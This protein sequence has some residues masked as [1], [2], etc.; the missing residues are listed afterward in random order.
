MKRVAKYLSGPIF[1]AVFALLP[2][3]EALGGGWSRLESP[4]TAALYRITFTGPSTGTAVGQRGLILRTRDGGI[5]WS[6]QTIGGLDFLS[7]VHFI[8]DSLG[9]VVG[10]GGAIFRTSDGGTTW[11]SQRTGPHPHLR[12]VFLNDPLRGTAVGDS[13][14]IL[15]TTD[16]G[17]TWLNQASPTSA[18]LTSVTF[19]GDSTGI[20]VGEDVILKTTDAGG[21]WRYVT[22]FGNL[23]DVSFADSLNGLSVG[24]FYGNGIIIKTTDGGETWHP[25]STLTL[26]TIWQGVSFPSPNYAVAVGNGPTIAHSTDGGHTWFYALLPST[27]SLLLS[28]SFVDSVTGFAAGTMGDLL[29]TTDGG[30]PILLLAPGN[31]SFSDPKSVTLTWHPSILR[32][33]RLQVSTVQDFSRNIVLDNS[34]LMDTVKVL[35]NLA[36]NTTYYWRVKGSSPL[37]ESPWSS[38][39]S[40]TTFDYPPVTVRELQEIS[41]DSL[42]AADSLQESDPRRWTL[43]ASAFLRD[44]VTFLGICVVP[45]GVII[46]DQSSNA[47]VVSDTTTNEVPWHG[48]LVQAG[49]GMPLGEFF[50]IEQGDLIKCTGVVH[51]DPEGSM[52]SN[53]LFELSNVRRIVRRKIPTT[54]INSVGNF[55]TGIYPQGQVRYSTGEQYEGMLVEFRNLT[56]VSYK[57]SLAGTFNVADG[58]GALISTTDASS[59]FTF[60]GHRDPFSTYSLPPRG[61]HIRLLRGLLMTDGMSDQ[62]RGYT[63]APILPGDLVIGFRG[64]TLAGILFNDINKN[65]IQDAGEPGFPGLRVDLTGKGQATILTDS[66]GKYH[67]SDLDPGTYTVH[68]RLPEGWQPVPPGADSLVVSLGLDDSV[69]GKN[70]PNY[71]RGNTISGRVVFDRRESG[72][73]HPEDQPIPDCRITVRGPTIDS[74]LTG[75]GGEYSFIRL[76]PGA[77]T[78]SAEARTGWQQSYPSA[79]YSLTLTGFGQEYPNTNF[80]FHRAQPRIRIPVTVSDLKIHVHKDVWWGVRP[81]ASYGLWGIDP[82][83]TIIDSIEGEFE[84]PPRSFAVIYGFFDTRLEDPRRLKGLF[85]EG[86]WTDIR[87]FISTAQRD[88]HYISFLPAYISGGGYPM[89]LRWSK[90][91]IRSS[92]NGPVTITDQASQTLDMK[93]VDSLLVTDNRI[94]SVLIT[95]QGPNLPAALTKQW[96]LVSVPP[97]YGST[98][99]RALFPSTVSPAF[100]WRPDS[101]YATDAEL[102]P[103]RGYW[104]NCSLAADT[105]LLLNSSPGAVDTIIVRKGWNIIGSAD[106]SV[107]PGTIESVPP[108]I[109]DGGILEYMGRYSLADTLEPF[110]GYWVKT[111]SDGKLILNPDHPFMKTA[112]DHLAEAREVLS[113][114]GKLTFRDAAGAE[115]EL[116]FS[117]GARI[118]GIDVRYFDLPPSPPAGI[119]D[120]RFA[121]GHMVETVEAGSRRSCAITVSSESYPLKIVWERQTDT[122]SASLT[123]GEKQFVMNS[124][125]QLTLMKPPGTIVLTLIGMIPLPEKFALMQNY[126]NPFNPLTAI[127]F[128][129]PEDCRVKLTLYDILGRQV[130]TLLDGEKKAGSYLIRLDAVNL[131]SGV[132]FYSIRAGR[133]NETKKMLLIR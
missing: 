38:V 76:P 45:P 5:S 121:S 111:S 42:L 112:I 13:G 98:S 21:S 25:P 129:I 103:G 114:C 116:Y 7:G 67:F 104:L 70:F 102:T 124:E 30:A 4:T 51:E 127:G 82:K 18:A 97:L 9:T 20:A 35:K 88:T 48:L 100:S 92:F 47:I 8:S 11:V 119:F 31:G 26:D 87:D 53:T 56:C 59:W 29:K 125:G 54:Y 118:K 68:E 75:S 133:F 37:W 28:V 14:T 10:S 96:S 15:Q 57:D 1:A 46:S 55:Y 27:D 94:F 79:S 126:P 128:D 23:N 105:T 106:R 117:S 72:S 108:G 36:F 6:T 2:A 86:G 44:T 115:Q 69:T 34:F 62:Y 130:R 41:R 12:G 49:P 66:I 80:S 122:I 109:I 73:F 24:D 63:V 19:S 123:V 22:S 101:G 89:E 64:S 43:Q 39:W 52:N 93:A 74:A 90:E 107:L 3:P 61:A 50:N 40:F 32:T 99:V 84:I 95:S 81:G 17:L 71:Y 131:P 120:A 60:R 77:Y 78:V 110:R 16:G 113:R 33:F 83:A 65:G 91:L 85:G 132:Y 58:S